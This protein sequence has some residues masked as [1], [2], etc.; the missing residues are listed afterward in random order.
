MVILAGLIAIVLGH[1]KMG[2]LTRFVSFSVM[3]GFLAGIAMLLILSQLPLVVGYEAEGPNRVAQTIQLLRN[4]E[5]VNFVTLGLGAL[6]L[7]L[8][9]GLR[10]TRAGMFS[11]LLAIAVPSLLVVLFRASSV[12]VVEDVGPISGGFPIP[13]IPSFGNIVPVVTGAFSLAVVTLVQGAGVSQSVPNPD[14]SQRSASRDFIAQGLANVGAGLCRGL[15][16]GGS[17][18]ATALNVASGAVRRWAGAFA[19]IWTAVL[20]IGFPFLIAAVAMPALGA[21]L[22]YAGFRSIKPADIFAVWRSG[23]PAQLAG[24]TTFIATLLL[25]IQAAV[26]L[27]VVLSALLYLNEAS[28]DVSVME[29]VKRDD[30]RIEERNAPKKLASNS[31]TVLDVYGH[32]FYAGAR[33]FER[34]LPDPNDAVHPVI[35]LRLRGRS[36]VGAT[37]IEVLSQY[38][39]RLAAAKGRL[40]LTGLSEAVYNHVTRAEK[41]A[42]SGPVRAYEVTPIIGESTEQAW[43]DAEAWLVALKNDSG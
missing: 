21:I 3:T 23:W 32:L 37:L 35:V 30:G 9:V 39:R 16:V 2:R 17:L 13:S 19:G 18:S 31:V 22:I 7:G 36:Q 24:I 38:A 41:L 28:T 33:T 25:P 10:Q 14:G 5:A 27:G 15:P 11:N 6:T 43:S 20:L 42:L 4:L 1:F 8:A 12:Q 34:L 29:I 40:Y 26:G